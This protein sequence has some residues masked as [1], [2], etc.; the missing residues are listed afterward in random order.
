MTPSFYRIVGVSEQGH[1]G[2]VASP[3]GQQLDDGPDLSV[4]F[5]HGHLALAAHE[6]ERVQIVR[7]CEN[8][9]LRGWGVS[10][11]DVGKSSRFV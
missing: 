1:D 3:Q 5:E 9:I 2:P 6:P 7:I 11:S 10:G 8:F 4:P